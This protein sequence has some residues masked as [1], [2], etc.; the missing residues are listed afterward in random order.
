MLD[1][2]IQLPLPRMTWQ[3]A[4]D[5]YGSDKPDVRFGFEIKDISDIAKDCSFK[6]FKDTVAHRLILSPRAGEN[7]PLEDVL[8]AV[9]PP[10]VQ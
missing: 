8:R 7:D 2:D 10:R 9:A 5:K 6:V 3:D 4:M 1:V